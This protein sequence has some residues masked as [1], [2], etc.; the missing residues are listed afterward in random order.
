MI[1]AKNSILLQ[2]KLE[3][4]LAYGGVPPTDDTETAEIDN[5]QEEEEADKQVQSVAGKLFIDIVM[6]V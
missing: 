1:N 4:E 6:F 2:R 3:R 5:N